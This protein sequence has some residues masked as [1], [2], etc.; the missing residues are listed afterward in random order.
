MD[1]QVKWSPQAVEDIEEIAAYIAKDSPRYAQ[2]VVDSCVD[3]SRR[4]T[5]L[6]LRGRVVPELGDSRYRKGFV[7]SYR[8]IYR[9]ESL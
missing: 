8:V 3:F 4:L 6:P 2:A 9:A 1:H 7:Y 5:R